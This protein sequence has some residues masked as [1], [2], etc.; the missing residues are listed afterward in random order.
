MI[1]S[2]NKVAER[3]VAHD[4]WMM[5]RLKSMLETTGVL[6]FRMNIVRMARFSSTVVVTPL[7]ESFILISLND[8]WDSLYSA[9][10]FV[11]S[12]EDFVSNGHLEQL[13][14]P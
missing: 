6:L 11:L 5:V 13:K 14:F 4:R 1:Y 2:A 12:L 8:R 10:H 7:K 3:T 9:T